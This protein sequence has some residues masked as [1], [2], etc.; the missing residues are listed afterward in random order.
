MYLKN[1]YIYK[2]KYQVFKTIKKS[3][4]GVKGNILIRSYAVIRTVK[5]I[6]RMKPTN[7]QARAGL[8][9]QMDEKKLDKKEKEKE[10]GKQCKKK[11]NKYT[12]NRKAKR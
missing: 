6:R 1:I 10:V 2:F 4:I 5:G 7:S 8:T 9:S 3:N 12:L 11:K